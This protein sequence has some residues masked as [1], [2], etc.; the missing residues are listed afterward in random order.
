[1]TNQ[2]ANRT[3]ADDPHAGLERNFIVEFLRERGHTLESVRRLPEA[4]AK[5]LMT[6]ASQYASSRLT[7]IE[8]RAHFVDEV[9]GTLPDA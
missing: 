1:M 6:E 4:A 5:Q 9:R 8:A 7:E 3:A 2:P